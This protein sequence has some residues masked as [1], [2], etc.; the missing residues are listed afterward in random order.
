MLHLLVAYDVIDDARRT[1]L[2]KF[3]MGYLDRVQKS[4]FEGK[5][6]DKRLASM[7]AGIEEIIDQEEDSVRIYDLCARCAPAMVVVGTGVYIEG[8]DR[9]VI[10]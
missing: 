9:D 8:P 3:L 6:E 5:I 7:K 10:I 4:V 2:A 1:R